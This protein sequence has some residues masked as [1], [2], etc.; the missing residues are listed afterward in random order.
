[1]P[2]ALLEAWSREFAQALEMMTGET[3]GVAVAPGDSGG[4]DCLWYT[5]RLGSLGT[6][7]AG[8]EEHVWLEIGTRALQGAGIDMVGPDDARSTWFEILQQAVGGA[9]RAVSKPGASVEVEAG[10][11]GGGAPEDATFYTATVTTPEGLKLT[12]P[13]AARLA[14]DKPAPGPV[15]RSSP[16]PAA[17]ELPPAAAGTM[18]AL[19]HVH[20]PISISFGQTQL[21]LK[22]VLKL[23][24]GSV[25]ELNRQPEEPVDVIVNDSVVARG[26]VVI[27][28][29]N[30]AV[31]IQ[32]IVSRQQRLRLPQGRSGTN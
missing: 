22:D 25:V 4:G 29:G 14:S 15:Q 32:E 21:R 13:L 27:V 9:A 16:N 12:I 30:Y 28:D 6:V 1:M 11:A 7:A 2:N 19:L 17:A 10:V 26:E 23:A 31:R 20:L 8:A 18:E 3:Y 24:T 5:H